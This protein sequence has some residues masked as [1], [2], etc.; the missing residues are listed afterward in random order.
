VVRVD[1]QR[2]ELIWTSAFGNGSLLAAAAARPALD[3][4]L[5]T[6]LQRDGLF[7]A[8]AGV[9]TTPADEARAYTALGLVKTL[10]A[11]GGIPEDDMRAQLW[12]QGVKELGGHERMVDSRPRL[13]ADMLATDRDSSWTLTPEG[14][15]FFASLKLPPGADAGRLKQQ[16]GKKLKPTGIFADQD[17]LVRTIQEA[18][19]GAF[20]LIKHFL[21]PQMTAFVAAH[22]DVMPSDAALAD[23]GGR[24]ELDAGAGV[25]RVRAGGGP[26]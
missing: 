22:P 14:R 9:Y 21:W 4:A 25:L 2:R 6:R 18:G 16:I 12:Q 20:M 23:Q 17:L 11:V 13:F 24:V 1:A 5:A 3:G 10:T 7:A 8:R 26:R 15:T 19:A